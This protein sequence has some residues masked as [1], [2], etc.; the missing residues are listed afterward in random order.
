MSCS[1]RPGLTEPRWT[2]LSCKKWLRWGLFNFPFEISFLTMPTL[3]KTSPAGASTKMVAQYAQNVRSGE[4]QKF[5]FGRRRN[6]KV[7]W[8]VF[9][10]TWFWIM[11]LELLI[12]GLWPKGSSKVQSRGCQGTRSNVLGWKRLPCIKGGK[13]LKGFS[14]QLRNT[15]VWDQW[16]GIS[17]LWYF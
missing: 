2:T 9:K 14:T 8:N 13:Y 10:S 7:S 5:D 12:A 17:D 15:Q 6:M 16:K 11:W 3:I 1:L 4:F